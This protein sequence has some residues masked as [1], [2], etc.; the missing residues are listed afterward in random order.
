MNN[1]IYE[2]KK[3]ICTQILKAGKN[4][5]NKLNES[6][7]NQISAFK[8]CYHKNFCKLVDIF[9]DEK[10]FYIITE[11]NSE[12]NILEYLQNLGIHNPFKEEEKICEIIHQLLI[13]VY[14][15]HKMG[16]LHRN[17]K[18]DSIVPNQKL[19]SSS[20]FDSNS[21]SSSSSNSNNNSKHKETI[22]NIY[23]YEFSNIKLL[24]LSLSKFLNVNEKIKE[25]YGTVGYLSPEMLSEHEYDLKID[26]WSI[27]IVTYLLL[28]GKLPFS[29]EYSERE[30]ARQTIH[31]TLSFQ[32]PKWEKISKEAKDFV[33]KLLI[34]DP[35]KRMNVK[36]ALIHPWIKKYYPLIVQKRMNSISTNGTNSTKNTNI[37]DEDNYEFEAF[38][39]PIDE[40]K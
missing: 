32:Q 3:Y 35:K 27:G 31:E 12:I 26:E 28:C 11:K 18:P 6:I 14:Y 17:I 4:F 33:N 2:G 10:Y 23:S 39:S 34:K 20:E 22:S 13:A 38:S 1:N 29:D 36:D 21:E 19:E 37:I 24:D 8:I 9:H 16:I 40:F 5:Q 30:I 7:F 25:P 15:L